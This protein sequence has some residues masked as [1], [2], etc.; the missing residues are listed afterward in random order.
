MSGAL[1]ILLALMLARVVEGGPGTTPGATAELT[2]GG[3]RQATHRNEAAAPHRASALRAVR[4]GAQ[5]PF[6][7]ARGLPARGRPPGACGLCRPGAGSSSRLTSS[8][9]VNQVCV[10]KSLIFRTN[11]PY[12]TDTIA[13][14]D[15]PDLFCV[16]LDDRK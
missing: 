4:G 10:E 15:G 8:R 7:P 5:S 3:P 2:A 6:F 9:S 12:H 14:S 13:V 11:I 16:Q 1:E